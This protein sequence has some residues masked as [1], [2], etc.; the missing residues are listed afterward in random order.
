[1]CGA[2]CQVEAVIEEIFAGGR[3]QSGIFLK[4]SLHAK[5]QRVF[6]HN[7]SFASKHHAFIS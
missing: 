7:V 6:F 4:F 1:M 3:G 2:S 5:T